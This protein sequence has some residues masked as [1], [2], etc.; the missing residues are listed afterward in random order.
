[1]WPG[2]LVV[3]VTAIARRDVKIVIVIRAR[4]KS[5]PP[6]VMIGLRLIICQHGLD[7]GWRCVGDVRIS[8]HLVLTDLADAGVKHAPGRGALHIKLSV[9]RVIRIKG[10]PEQTLLT[11]ALKVRNRQK[12]RRVQ[13]SRVQIQNANLS[14]LLNNE[15][16][17][18][19][20]RRRG[21]KNR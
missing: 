16:T 18:E 9:G 14:T 17:I 3:A 2:A 20:T 15:Q 13:Q 12:R 5:N 8:R 1:M 4:T 10:E 6:A 11:A 21:N 7:I 19:V